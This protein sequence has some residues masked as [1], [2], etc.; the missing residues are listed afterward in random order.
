MTIKDINIELANT[1]LENN[2]Y[3]T[4]LDVQNKEIL[5]L[6]TNEKLNLAKLSKWSKQA[7][8]VKY[9][10]IYKT[11][12]VESNDCKQ[13]KNRLDFVKQLDFNKL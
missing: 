6:R 10:P 13:V 5:Q 4:M 3:K 1:K 8:E 11:K 7:K 9:R 2:R 12:K